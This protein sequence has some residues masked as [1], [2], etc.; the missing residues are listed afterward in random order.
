ME[1]ESKP[2]SKFEKIKFA[3]FKWLAISDKIG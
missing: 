1:N 3:G 2:V